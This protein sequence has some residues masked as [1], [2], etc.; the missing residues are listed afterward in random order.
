MLEVYHPFCEE[1]WRFNEDPE[2]S[3]K[4]WKPD[5]FPKKN[6]M[7]EIWRFNKNSEKSG[8]PDRFPEK[9]IILSYMRSK[10]SIL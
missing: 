10:P 6:H 5:N 1:I 4:F 9:K 8:K 3:E 7:G 2:K